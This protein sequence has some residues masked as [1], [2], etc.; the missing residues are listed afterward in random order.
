MV[1]A[2]CGSMADCTPLL[3]LCS[4][5]SCADAPCKVIVP[6]IVCVPAASKVSVRAVAT[7]LVKFLNVVEPVMDWFAPLRVTVPLP[8]ANV[9]PVLFQLPA[10][11][12]LFAPADK[13]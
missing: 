4:E 2:P 13:V 1:R 7:C 11:L 6:P 10:R 12:M 8:G 3:L 9:P 5:R